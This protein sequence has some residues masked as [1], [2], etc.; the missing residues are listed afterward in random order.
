MTDVQNIPPASP[1]VMVAAGGTGGHLFPAESLSAALAKRGIG[2]VL[3]TDNR[4]AKFGD[5]FKSLHVV[6]SATLRGRDPLSV[7]RTAVT[8]TVGL[9]KAAMLMRKV[10]PSIVV[11]F[12]GY[13]SVPPVF[14][15]SIMKIPTLLHEQNAVMGRANRFLASRVSAIATGFAGVTDKDKALEIKT[16]CIGNPL[17]PAVIAAADTPYPAIEPNGPLHILVFGGSQ[18]ASIMAD[19]VPPAVAKLP[20]HLQMRLK[21]VQ[22]VREEDMTRV[23]DIYT[24]AQVAHEIAPF[25][26]DLPARMAAAHLV[27][28]RSG[29]GTVAELSAIGR[30]GILVPLP[31]AL[32]QDQ[33]ANALVLE[34]A[35]GAIRILQ[36]DFTPD[37]L[38][39]EIDALAA[40]PGR[41]ATMA[42]RAKGIGALD[43]ADRLADLV[44]KVARVAA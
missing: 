26:T 18:G 22:Q 23:R 42:S 9:G 41:L 44:L 34:K 30:P 2:T 28:S 7:L 3:A 27:V 37:R 1:L 12:G 6:P 8:M 40:D 11:G 19:I 29:A 36:K 31:H 43:A 20:P 17:R 13:P 10:R 14:V 4:A 5:H 25:F 21:I 32:D 33:A 16:T 39:S 15:A 38:A 35:G 24:R